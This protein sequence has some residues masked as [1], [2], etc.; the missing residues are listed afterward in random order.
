MIFI[1]LFNS[2]WSVQILISR[3]KSF[4]I[5]QICRFIK[6]RIS[7]VLRM[8][9]LVLST[10]SPC[11]LPAG[12][13]RKQNNCFLLIKSIHFNKYLSCIHSERTKKYLNKQTNI[14]VEPTASTLCPESERQKPYNFL[15]L[16]FLGFV[17]GFSLAVVKR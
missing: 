8:F 3:A 14:I 4:V 9:F 6:S 7:W 10:N 15:F 11:K 5:D 13:N 2:W 17:N 12:Q 16:F 1:T